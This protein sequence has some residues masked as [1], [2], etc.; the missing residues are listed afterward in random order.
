MDFQTDPTNRQRFRQFLNNRMQPPMMQQPSMMQAPM[1]QPPAHMP[2]ILPEIDIFAPQGFED[3]GSVPPRN[4]DIRGQDHMLSYITPDEADI[5][6]ALGGSGEA[7]P[8]G[9]PAYIPDDGNRGSGTDTSDAPSG[10]SGGPSGGDFG[11]SDADEEGDASQVGDMFDSY[12]ESDS[13]ADEQ[14]NAI[15]EQAVIDKIVSD[16]DSGDAINQAIQNAMSSG[17][18]RVSAGFVDPA[19]V[20]NVGVRVLLQRL[21]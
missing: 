6:K 20:G 2:P 19:N 17:S 12:D 16:N 8:M 21:I 18:N 10:P 14:G 15:V 5:L 3:G 1:M 11:G 13:D 7:G 9:I 4:T